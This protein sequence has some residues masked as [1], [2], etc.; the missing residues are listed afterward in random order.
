MKQ[1]FRSTILALALLAGSITLT[2]QEVNTLYFLEN[3]P[4]RHLFNPALMPVSN[5]YISFTPLGYT[6]L[7]AGNNSLTLSDVFFV[8]K[9]G[10]TI[11]AFNQGQTDLFLKK[12]RQSTLVN[13]DMTTT[14]LA[15][16]ARTKKG[17]YFHGGIFLRADGGLGLPKDLFNAI[18]VRQDPNNPKAA[19][20]VG[21]DLTNGMN[22]K[23]LNFDAQAYLEIGGGYTRPLNDQWTLG[24][25]LK[26]LLGLANARVNFSQLSVT[27]EYNPGN[28]STTQPYPDK[29]NMSVQGTMNIAMPGAIDPM[30]IMPAN[31][32]GMFDNI[33]QRLSN[34]FAPYT[35]ANPNIGQLMTPAGYGAAIDFGFTYKPI[36]YVQIAAAV[37]D[38][39]FIYWTNGLLGNVAGNVA[40]DGIGTVQYNSDAQ[41][42]QQQITDKWNQ[43]VSDLGKAITPASPTKGGYAR[44]AR[45]RLN[46]SVDGLFWENRVGVGILSQT[47]FVDHWPYAYEELTI[48]GFFRPVNWFNIAASYSILN[49]KGGTLGA[50]LGFA[51][52]DGI[53]MT[54]ATDFIPCYYADMSPL[55]KSATPQYYLP[56]KSPG[57]NIAF[58]FSI[59]WGTNKKRDAD[60]DGILDNLDMCPHTP[61]NVRVDKFGCPIDTDGDGIPDYLDEGP[62]TPAAAYG[63]VD[64][65]G[66]VKDGDLDGVPDYLDLCPDTPE[67]ARSSVDENGCT[68]DTDG[69]GVPDYRDDC[70]NTL[71]EAAAFVDEHGCDKDSDGDGVPDYLDK[72][73]NT[74]EEAYNFIDEHGCPL[75]LDE[76]GVPDYLDKCPRT[77]YAARQY[78]DSCGCDKDSDRDGVPDYLD[79]CPYVPG[80]KE[81]KG[82]P[83]LKRAVTTLLK[84]AMSGIQF[85]TGKA[86][87]VKKSY[88]ILDQIAT[89]FKENPSYIIEVQGH[90]DNVGNAEVNLNLSEK[91][92]QAV[93]DYLI[94]AGVDSNRLSARGYGSTMP[95]DDNKTKAG[96]AKNRRV[97]FKI[98]FEE[99][100]YELINDHNPGDQSA[101]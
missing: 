34:M 36:K 81:N 88:P 101:Q 13:F 4:E 93:R 96:R 18:T 48:G 76:D 22:I 79:E 25:K 80:V 87:I 100:N 89:V 6:S 44:L 94:K 75:D 54:L 55:T 60:R 45:T 1:F 69:D 24:G 47:K 92:A 2:A 31:G 5:G 20:G 15:F 57:V 74:P 49:G 19:T 59:V 98:T 50:A 83:Q 71:P 58:G 66:C 91:R 26:L 42:M 33:G 17:G 73:P 40:F 3:S 82:C 95:I 85:E 8:D 78:V 43:F 23:G 41:A 64:A 72:C 46:V 38:L 99:V 28:S 27:P 61:R 7:W 68:R 29:F 63:L 97:E 51:P 70:P 65:A 12:L 32:E 11:T 86:T 37:N 90:T 21:I 16:G 84:K 9:N 52:Y 14:I 67:E 62:N 53:M 56:Y 77:V 10:Q 30:G 39:G 35:A